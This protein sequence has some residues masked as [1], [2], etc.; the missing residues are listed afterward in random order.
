MVNPLGE[1]LVAVRRNFEQIRT[2]TSQRTICSLPFLFFPT[3]SLCQKAKKKKK[4]TEMG[5]D[6]SRWYGMGALALFGVVLLIVGAEAFRLPTITAAEYRQISSS[7]KYGLLLIV[8]PPNCDADALDS[9]PDGCRDILQ[10]G[11]DVNRHVASFARTLHLKADVHDCKE[12]EFDIV[13]PT[14]LF[15]SPDRKLPYLIVESRTA[16][17]IVRE[18]RA[19]LRGETSDRSQTFFSHHERVIPLTDEE[20]GKYVLRGGNKWLIAFHR[21]MTNLRVHQ[22]LPLLEK[23]SAK[24]LSADV[25]VGMFD[26]AEPHRWAE[27]FL[28]TRGDASVVRILLF[29]GNAFENVEYHGPWEVDA[30]VA[31]VHHPLLDPA[32]QQKTNDARIRELEE[33]LLADLTKKEEQEKQQRKQEELEPH[34]DDTQQRSPSHSRKG[35]L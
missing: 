6:A 35:D 13:P 17:G 16:Q 33:E 2:S 23:A 19:H 7:T 11:R 8:T 31:F 29:T 3:L 27:Q 18:L 22:L 32:E 25:H 10:F 1:Y 9:A 26:V 28:D 4:S 12:L 15:I 24:L 34:G 21:G 14:V 5:L 30:L 20:F